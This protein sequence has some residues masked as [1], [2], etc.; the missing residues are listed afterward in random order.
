MSLL[1]RLRG[2]ITLGKGV[3]KGLSEEAAG[4]DPIALF[5]AWYRDARRAGLYLP[6]AVTLATATP[7]G[8]PSARM[9]LLKGF[10]ERGFRFFTNYRSAKGRQLAAVPNAAL[11]LYWREL[12]R[13]VRARGRVERLPAE[14]SDAYFASRPREAQL[15]AIASPQSEP[16]AS[17]DE[18]DRR[19]RELGESLGSAEPE[20]PASWGG[21]VLHPAE[22]EV[23]QGQVG[24]L[25]DRFRYTKDGERW[26]IDRL[27]P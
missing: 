6:E 24:R 7:D 11:I 27:A 20:R 19:V 14:E 2:L 25:H 26:R 4:P 21:Y 10:D 23:W 12:D 13:Q 3:L 16:I 8:V 15:G 5:A 9:M 1:S 17:R 18:L 22:I